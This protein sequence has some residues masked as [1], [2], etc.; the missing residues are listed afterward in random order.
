MTHALRVAAA[1]ITAVALSSQVAH[2]QDATTTEP[3]EPTSYATLIEAAVAEFGAGRFAEA[4]ALF[5][6]A[7]DVYPNARTLRGI[8][9]SS[10]ELRDYPAAVRAL[11]ASLEETRRA[12]TD[13][14]RAQV[15]DLLLRARAF[16]GRFVVP[17][18]PAGSRLYLDGTGV[19]VA[20]EWPEQEGELLVG[21]GDHEVTIRAPEGR[22]ARARLVVRG[23]EDE[24]LDIDTSPL[25]PPREEPPRVEPE[26]AP[27][28]PPP[29]YEPPREEGSDPAPWIVAGVG[30]AAIVTGAILLGVGLH[31]ISSVEN[32]RMHTEW[33]AISDANDRAPVLTGVGIA[34]IGIG[35]AGAVA[36]IVW[37][38][39]GDGTRG[40]ERQRVE[41]RV[42]PTS[43]AVGGSF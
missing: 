13:E 17:I 2:A 35:T 33:S 22:T 34:L 7:H 32:A 4:R 36:G 37:G 29:A 30:G 15:N 26:P 14:Q 11:S 8:G 1:L 40:R 5:R 42:G 24:P 12:L 21:V 41:L 31:D 20:G 28:V 43:L 10:F 39:L 16:V 23:R 19:E 6:S 3:P 18:A 9:M 25:A 38:A 27:L